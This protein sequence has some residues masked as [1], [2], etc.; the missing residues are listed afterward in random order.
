MSITQLISRYSLSVTPKITFPV[1]KTWPEYEIIYKFSLNKR[2]LSHLIKVFYTNELD[3]ET[4]IFTEQRSRRWKFYRNKYDIKEISLSGTISGNFFYIPKSPDLESIINFLSAIYLTS[5]MD[6]VQI[7]DNNKELALDLIIKKLNDYAQTSVTGSNNQRYA[8][9]NVLANN[10]KKIESSDYLQ[11]IFY[12]EP[13]DKDIFSE[14]PSIYDINAALLNERIISIEGPLHTE[15]KDINV[16]A[17]ARMMFNSEDSH[18]LYYDILDTYDEI[19]TRP[20]TLYLNAFRDFAHQI[21]SNN[22]N[23]RNHNYN[24]RPRRRINY[25][26]N[27]PYT[28]R[29]EEPEESPIQDYF[30]PEAEEHRRRVLTAKRRRY[31]GRGYNIEED[32]FEDE[33]SPITNLFTELSSR[34]WNT[35]HGYFS[36]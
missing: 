35:I 22:L 34:I 10:D 13:I 11:V 23:I 25:R 14:Q 7:L 8:I 15:N 2:T 17:N 31:R 26:E 20:N 5:F 33:I 21:P 28:R 1:G 16:V 6:D 18:I 24:L 9:L 3:F 36:N 4:N 32:R 30:S 19:Q 12:L 29:R 27:R